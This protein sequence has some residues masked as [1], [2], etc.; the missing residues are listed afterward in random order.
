MSERIHCNF[1]I[2]K[3]LPPIE[4]DFS[5]DFQVK[6]SVSLYANTFIGIKEPGGTEAMSPQHF[7]MM[8]KKWFQDEPLQPNEN[9]PFCFGM[10]P[11]AK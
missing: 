10:R 1:L 6:S 3:N 2:N 7:A 9:V 8:I 4:G 5:N 11:V